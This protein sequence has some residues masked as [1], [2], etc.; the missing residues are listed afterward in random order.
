MLKIVR[1]SSS[2]LGR[3]W[4][5]HNGSQAIIVSTAGCLDIDD[6]VKVVKKEL[7]K[8]VSGIDGNDFTLYRTFV[9]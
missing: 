9:E 8:Q 3:L 6:F 5:K 2:R 7:L 4:V 1:Y